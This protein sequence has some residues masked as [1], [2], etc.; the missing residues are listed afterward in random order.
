MFSSQIGKN[1]VTAIDRLCAE[2]RERMDVR[3]RKGTEGGK[4]SIKI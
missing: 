1:D 3:K 4:N 2:R